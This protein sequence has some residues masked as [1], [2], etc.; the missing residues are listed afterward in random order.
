MILTAFFQKPEGSSGAEGKMVENG[1]IRLTVIWGGGTD[2]I[3]YAVGVCNDILVVEEVQ[4]IALP[5]GDPSEGLLVIRLVRHRAFHLAEYGL[6][7]TLLKCGEHLCAIAGGAKLGIDGDIADIQVT[8]CRDSEGKSAE[9]L[10]VMEGVQLHGGVQKAYKCHSGKGQSL[11][12]RE[13][14]MI[15]RLHM[16]KE[17]GEGGYRGYGHGQIPH[18]L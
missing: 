6:G 1:Q 17:A 10:L 16:P 13:S 3:L 18:S 5:E 11:V 12:F 7:K 14:G 4:T 8:V 15:K 2:Q 9:Y